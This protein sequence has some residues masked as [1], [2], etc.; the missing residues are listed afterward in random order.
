[1]TTL[2][3]YPYWPSE[4]L[5]DVKDQLRTIC[6]IRK[7][8]ITEIQNF[9]NIFW[10]GRTVGKIPTDSDDVT[11]GDKIG[12]LSY[13]YNSGTPYLYVLMD[14]AADGKWIRFA[15]STF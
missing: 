9:T 10:S 7:D 2:R 6:N 14:D 8:D 5:D 13:T 15:G 3:E 12:D 4:T 11:T 1:M